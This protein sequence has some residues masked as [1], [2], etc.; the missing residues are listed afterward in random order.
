MHFSAANTNAFFQADKV[1][2]SKRSSRA[3]FKDS[4]K[5]LE[6]KAGIVTGNRALNLINPHAIGIVPFGLKVAGKKIESF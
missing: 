5:E 1:R 4:T 3:E 6:P 2:D